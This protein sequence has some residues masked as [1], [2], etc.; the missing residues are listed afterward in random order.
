MDP[1]LI[2]ALSPVV[3]IVTFCAARGYPHPLI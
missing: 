2:F 1:V 3:W